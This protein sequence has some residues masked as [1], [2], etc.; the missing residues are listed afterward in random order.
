MLPVCMTLQ[1]LFGKWH[2]TGMPTYVHNAVYYV[3][4]MYILTHRSSHLTNFFHQL[5]G[6]LAIC[7]KTIRTLRGGWDTLTGDWIRGSPP[8]YSQGWLDYKGHSIV[9]IWT[10]PAIQDRG[11]PS[12]INYKATQEESTFNH[13]L[14]PWLTLQASS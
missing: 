3:I 4:Q 13:P 2:C 8:D 10:V 12:K 9:L 5:T 6:G 7:T 1:F 11:S 14:F